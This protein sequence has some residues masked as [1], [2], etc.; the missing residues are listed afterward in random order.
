MFQSGWRGFSD[1]LA[2]LDVSLSFC[3][4]SLWTSAAAHCILV[5]IA[6]EL[7][8]LCVF[9]KGN[10]YLQR[11]HKSILKKGL[12]KA[13]LSEKNRGIHCEN[14]PAHWLS[15]FFSEPQYPELSD[16]FHINHVTLLNKWHSALLAQSTWEH[17]CSFSMSA[18]NALLDGPGWHNDVKVRGWHVTHPCSVRAVVPNQRPHDKM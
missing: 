12:S 16:T 3:L 17:P 1:P 5:C 9:K 11:V 8:G 6:T 18:E 14:V 4:S 15:F 2:H 10:F 13:V 7:L